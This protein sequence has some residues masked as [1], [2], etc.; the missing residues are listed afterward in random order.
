MQVI[1]KIAPTK[2][3]RED[4]AAPSRVTARTAHTVINWGVMQGMVQEEPSGRLEIK[5]TIS[6]AHADASRGKDCIHEGRSGG[7]CRIKKAQYK[8]SADDN[9]VEGPTRHEYGR[10]QAPGRQSISRK[11]TTNQGCTQE[12]QPGGRRHTSM[13]RRRQQP[14]TQ[15]SMEEYARHGRSRAGLFVNI[16]QSKAHHEASQW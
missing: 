12:G 1:L 16:D 2:V 10:S 13:S 15:R 8:K 5:T 4:G 3:N 6:K 9:Q 11:S 14:R 7:W